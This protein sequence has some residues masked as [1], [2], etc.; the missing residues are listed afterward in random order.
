MLKLKSVEDLKIVIT[1]IYH[2]VKVNPFEM[3]R[4]HFQQRNKNYARE[5]NG[6]YRTKKYMT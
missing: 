5:L 6:N 3:K 2:E 4:K 1:P